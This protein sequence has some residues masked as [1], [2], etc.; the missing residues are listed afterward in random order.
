MLYI[1]VILIICIHILL[2][3]RSLAYGSAFFIAVKM[4]IPTPTR[5]GGLSLYAIM[6]LIL[7]FFSFV[8]RTIWI[9]DTR[10]L[11]IAVFPFI[12]LIIPISLLGLFGVVD[13]SFQYYRLVQFSITEILPFFLLIISIKNKDELQVC[14]KT[15]IYSYIVIGIWGIITY[16][17]H[18]NIYVMAFANAFNYENE[19]FIGD[20]SDAIRGM[21]TSIATGNQAEGAIPWGQISLVLLS[22]GLFYNDI[23][24]KNIKNIFVLLAMLNCFL[25]TKRSAIVPMILIVGYTLIKEGFFR[26][27]YF[28]R[29]LSLLFLIIVLYF[30]VP[31]LRKVYHE[32]IE[33]SVFFWDDK[34]ADRNDFGGSSKEMRKSQIIYVNNL[35]S[36]H[37]L[38]GLGYGYPIIHNMKYQG[39]TDALY[40]ESVY[41]YVIASSGYI[42][43]LIWVIFFIKLIKETKSICSKKMDNI[44]L[45]G[46]YILSILLTNIYGSFA[47]YMIVTALFIKHKQLYDINPSS[48][49]LK[50]Q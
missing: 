19:M 27:K 42:G 31:T 48:N 47:Y 12:F 9:K 36:D 6:L 11:R 26:R 43:L 24:N 44:V 2:C 40:F 38:T 13:Y 46:G 5:I 34:L 8:R 29:V 15:L 30:F 25:S 3:Y 50:N 32:N 41:L 20:G 21:L 16:L 23:H 1:V 18:T 35:I 28:M 7:L 4:V 17:M 22:F 39:A 33:P 37:F 10:N 49:K 14:V 45:H